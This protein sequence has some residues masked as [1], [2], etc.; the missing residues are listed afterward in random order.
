MGL[1]PG[2][3]AGGQ[4]A[5]L[6]T[7]NPSP[8]VVAA[9]QELEVSRG[10][11]A[12]KLTEMYLAAV[13]V[14]ANPGLPDRHA[15]AAHALR[16]LIEKAGACVGVIWQEVG[17]PKEWLGHIVRQHQRAQKQSTLPS[18]KSE[19]R[20]LDKLILARGKELEKTSTRRARLE[21]TVKVL[22]INEPLPEPAQQ[23]RLH[24]FWKLDIRLIDIAHHKSAVTEAEMERR[25]GEL[26]AFILE[27]RRPPDVVAD[28]AGLGSIIDAGEKEQ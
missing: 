7:G 4:P 12:P 24:A 18:N 22:D 17:Q 2:E 23:Q 14:M 13:A 26:E 19:W 21:E 11:G 16:E 10:V 20:K 27:L 15:L 5:G 25:V 28:R 3:S 8:E 6:A 9:L 1:G